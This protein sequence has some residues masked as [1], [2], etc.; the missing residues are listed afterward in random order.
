MTTAV[1][2]QPAD[3]A[4]RLRRELAALRDG[5][6]DLAGDY[7]STIELAG[8][9]RDRRAAAGR[10]V[11]VDSVLLDLEASIR[12]APPPLLEDVHRGAGRASCSELAGEVERLRAELDR[13]MRLHLAFARTALQR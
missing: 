3:E 1:P 4:L 12:S 8:H 7:D 11:D 10:P 9:L 6:K 2:A 5:V 13:L